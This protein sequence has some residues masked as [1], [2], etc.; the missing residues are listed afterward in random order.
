MLKHPVKK[1]CLAFRKSLLK[2]KNQCQ[3]YDLNI[4]LIYRDTTS[5]NFVFLT[6]SDL[7]N[8]I[9]EFGMLSIVRYFEQNIRYF[10]Q[11][12]R[13]FEQNMA[14]YQVQSWKGE[15]GKSANHTTDLLQIGQID[16]QII[17]QKI[18]R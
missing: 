14:F 1:L 17:R 11:N 5:T 13:Y 6:Y 12:I 3:G 8:S 9:C 4:Y 18:D 16:R 2:L 10:E 7:S 15:T